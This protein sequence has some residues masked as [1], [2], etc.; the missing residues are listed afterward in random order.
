MA[1]LRT[2]QDPDLKKDLVTL[3]MIKDVNISHSGVVSL[4]VVLTTPACPMKAQ[5]EAEVKAAVTG[6]AGVTGV[7]VKMDASVKKSQ[8][9]HSKSQA[10]EGVKHIIAVSSGKGGV[11]K[12][13][14]AVNLAV[15]L[16]LEGAKV[17]LMD[18]DVYGPN[19]PTMMGATDGPTLEKTEKGDRLVPPSAHGV[20]V[21]SMGFLVSN[22]DQPIVWRGPMLHSVVQQFC[23]QVNWGELDYLIVDMPPG[24]GD[25]QLSLAQLV[26]VS[27]AVMVTTPQE[28]SLQDVRKAYGMFEN[29]KVPI[30]GLVENMSYFI[31]DG[32]DKKHFMFG[33]GGGKALAKRFNSTLLGQVPLVAGVR[34]GGD[35][36]KPVVL[37][38]PQSEPAKIFREMARQIAQKLA[39]MSE[40]EID[41]SAQI[42]VGKFN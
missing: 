35:D 1:A 12:S 11:G 40:S 17:G 29:V 24:T 37:R 3:D 26:P 6:V 23:H 41:P 30:L 25:V 32:C 10:I 34:E 38:H 7:E 36:G 9:S 15:S 16:S 4:R 31:C 13:T 5:I 22:P 39:L 14:V 2:V 27:G 33:D 19:I 42:T 21:L 18:A 8:S 28:V 20:K